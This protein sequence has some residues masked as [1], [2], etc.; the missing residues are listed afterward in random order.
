MPP[1]TYATFESPLGEL[2]L[3]GDGGRLQ[4]LLIGE[5]DR[6]AARLAGLPRDQRAHAAAIAQLEQYFAGE[7]TE[8]ELELDAR[9]TPFQREVWAALR[10]IPFGET[11]SYGEIAAAVGRPRAARAVGSANNRNPIAI[12][13]PC[14]RVVGAGGALV[15]YAG[16]LGCKTWLLEHEDAVARSANSSS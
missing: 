5:G 1:T 7:R 2:L 4:L 16:G 13:V 8:F 14:H 10:E 12:V 6:Y 11:R 9:G 3:A 15:G